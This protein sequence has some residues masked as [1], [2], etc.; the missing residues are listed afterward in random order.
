MASITHH[1]N[2]KTGTVY[3]YS[4]ES[5]WDKEKKAPRNKQK[6]LGKLDPETGELIPSKK[7]RKEANQTIAKFD[8]PVTTKVAGP[9]LILEAL[10][11]KHNIKELLKECFPEDYNFILSMVYYIVHKGGPLSNADTWSEANIHP[12][13]QSIA[14]QRISELLNRLTKDRCQHFLSLWLKQIQENDWLCYDITSISSYARH[15]EYLEQG[16]NRDGDSL[17]QIN[18]AMLFGQESRLPAYYKYLPGSINDVSTLK[19]TAKSLGYLGAKKM[20][21]VL[22]K[23]FYSLTNIDKL[24]AC[25]HKFTI[26][27]PNGR[28]WVREI[29]DKHLDNVAS[30]KNYIITGENEAL[31]A[32]TEFYKWGEKKHRSWVHIFYNAERAAY[33]FDTFIRKLINCKEK[34]LKGKTIEEIDK[35]LRKYLIVKQTP[36][37]GLQVEFNEEEIQKKRG[38]Y[39]GFFCIFS[40]KIKDAKEALR[41]YRNKDVVENCFDDLKNHMDMKRLRVHTSPTMN[42]RLFLQFVALIYI[43]SIRSEIQNDKKLQ[44]FTAR[45]VLEAMETLVKVKYANKYGEVFTE[46]SL[47]QRKIMDIFGV[48]LPA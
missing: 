5:Y 13:G 35:N 23:G 7:R 37:R 28:K 4:V 36:K 1:R 26:A 12:I 10:T 48:E 41:V 44:Y 29:I 6:C 24:F 27:L 14:S 39:S 18:L 38:K 19:T 31:Y 8:T 32:V 15:N 9:S 3:V 22:D 11:D 21:F 30:P 34:L 43:S 42:G 16:Y 47:T 46:T 25:G 40:N 2:K 33:S 17:E 45:K 20:N